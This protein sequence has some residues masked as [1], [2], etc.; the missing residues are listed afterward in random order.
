MKEPSR[1]SHIQTAC[2]YEIWKIM[3]KI[4]PPCRTNI[5]DVK[6]PLPISSPGQKDQGQVSEA[7]FEPN[8]T[9]AAEP[10]ILSQGKMVNSRLFSQ[11]LHNMES[12]DLLR[13]CRDSV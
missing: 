9:T 6:Q 2:S 13:F 10:L 5:W 4:G 1:V 8:N 11:A 3:R 7:A 12:N